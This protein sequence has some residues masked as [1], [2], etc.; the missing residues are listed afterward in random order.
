MNV[1]ITGAKGFVGKNLTEALKNIRDGKDRTHPE[2][3]IGELYLYDVDSAAGDLAKYCK[4]AD[5]VF[6]LAGVNRPKETS[7]YMDG[8]FSFASDLL[9][10]LK[11][12]GN[13]C[14]VMLSSS[15]QASL[16]GRFAGSEYGKSKLAGEELFFDYAKDTGAEVYVYRFPNL[17]GKWCRPNYNSAI[18]TFCH[19]IANGLPIQVNDPSVDMDVLYI[20]DLIN[21]M[22]C[23]MASHPHRCDFDG[24]KPVAKSDGKYCYAPVYYETTLGYLAETIKSFS[25]MRESLGVPDATNELESKLYSA[26]LSY[27]PVSSFIYDLRMNEDERGSFTEIIRSKSAG[28]FSVNIIKPGIVKGNHWHHSKH[29]KFVVVSGEAI[30]R[31][32]KIGTDENGKEYPISEYRV[33]GKHIQVVDMIPGY[34]HCIENLSETKELVVFM[35]ANECFD[36]KRPETYAEN[37]NCK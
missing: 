12:A 35:W 30:I 19:N 29:E 34:A 32:R 4:K 9:N 24:V 1:L 27:L 2:I 36:P 21:E 7:E 23:A 15:M 17:F 31:L 22:L 28:Q 6:N 11:T 3:N 26:W 13:K 14:P 25:A 5:F 37:V 18:A 20:D 33:S 10:A 8:N 16:S